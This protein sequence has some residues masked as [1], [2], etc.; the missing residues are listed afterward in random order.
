MRLRSGVCALAMGLT[1]LPVFVGACGQ[2]ARIPE[3][4]DRYSAPVAT[5]RSAQDA[6]VWADDYCSAVVGLVEAISEAPSVDPSTPQRAS[7]TSID[8]LGG[9]IDGLDDTVRRLDDLAPSPVAGGDDVAGTAIG[10]FLG[11]RN[12]ALAA[13]QELGAAPAGSEQSRRALDITSAVLQEVAELELLRGVERIPELAASSRQA[14][15]CRQLADPAPAERTG[16][17]TGPAGPGV[18]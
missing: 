7:Q 3:S 9:V 8:M 17:I 14:P 10:N 2:P 12:R 4:G 1:V 6:V 5:P 11:I 13:Q 18:Y 16:G 15:S